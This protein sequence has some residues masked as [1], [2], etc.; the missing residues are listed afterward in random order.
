MRMSQR[1]DRWMEWYVKPED[2]KSD[3]IKAIWQ[4][5]WIQNEE[6][7]QKWLNKAKELFGE[8]Y[9]RGALIKASWKISLD[10]H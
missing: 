6:I 2:R 10:L 5:N 3:F 9:V 4:L 1:I 7:K 8:D